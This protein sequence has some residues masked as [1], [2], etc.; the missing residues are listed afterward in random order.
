M[1]PQTRRTALRCLGTGLLGLVAG[2]TEAPGDVSS[3]SALT[4]GSPTEPTT[5]H[6][7]SGVSVTPCPERPDSFTRDSAR[8]FA[9][10]FETAYLEHET[11]R[12]A[13]GLVSVTVD[14]VTRKKSSVTQTT[15]GWIVRFYVQGPATRYED[16][17]H[18]DPGTL[19][20]HYYLSDEQT[21]RVEQFDGEPDP[22][23]RGREVHCPP[24]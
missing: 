11:A 2:C 19:H 1:V 18:G 17:T 10:Q 16:G 12:E 3:N 4:T 22:R 7:I 23:Q 21:R 9:F 6:V 8:Q 15:N 20:V 24:E 5:P 13:E 14:I